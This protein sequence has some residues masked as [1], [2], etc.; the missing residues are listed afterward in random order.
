MIDIPKDIYSAKKLW[1]K[2]RK[3]YLEHIGSND[4]AIQEDQEL[5]ILAQSL[6]KLGLFLYSLPHIKPHIEAW[7]VDIKF[8]T[9]IPFQKID[10]DC[11]VSGDHLEDLI[12]DSASF[13]SRVGGP[14][15]HNIQTDISNMGFTITD[16]GFSG[17]GGHMGVPCTD[18]GKEIIINMIWAK[19]HKAI[20][21]HL[22]F[23]IISWFRPKFMK[24]WEYNDIMEFLDE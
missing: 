16:R 4:P 14:L 2:S 11:G 13:M 9:E 20:E 12:N 10:I 21:G 24:L 15:L 23:P 18:N 5:S 6:D 19:Y 7:M 8:G 1:A 3:E 17:S 22:V